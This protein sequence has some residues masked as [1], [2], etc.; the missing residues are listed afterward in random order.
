[1]INF[2]N[3]ATTYPKP[4]SVRKAAADAMV[5]YGGN[6][7]RSGH[8]LSIQTAEA[9]YRAR[10]TAADFFGAQ[11]DNTVF[12]SNCTH[13]LNL[14]IKGIV[15]RGGHIVISSLEHNSAARPVHAMLKEDCSYDIAEISE[16]DD[17]TV[18]NF[19]RLISPQTEAVV[20]TLGSNVTGRIPPFERIGKLCKERGKCFIADGAQACGVINVKLSQG[21]NILCTAGHKSLYGPSGTG[22]LV[23]DGKFDITPLM[24]GG[25]GSTSLELEQPDFLPDS[26]ESGTVNTSGIIGLGEGIRFVSTLGTDKIFAHETALCSQFINGL[27][28]L[29]NVVIYRG[30]GSYLPIVS[31]NING[32][33]SN[34]TA[35]MLSDMGFALRGGLHCSS[36]A[37]RYIGTAPEGTVRF[38]PSVFSTKSEVDGLLAAVR[39]ISAMA[40]KSGGVMGKGQELH[41]L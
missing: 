12:T 19:A 5:C 15:K 4:L 24:E 23:S 21:I 6:P 18:E 14:A 22:L 38:S 13:A 40:D 35:A 34:E 7:G 9:V 27:R 30:E 31:F 11:T 39:K 41:A 16:D 36:L 37:H 1:M 32:F 33:T 25:T 29:E 28:L 17:A 8:K 2:D 10:Q 20:C 3:S 26:L